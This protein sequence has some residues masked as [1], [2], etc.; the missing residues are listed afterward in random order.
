VIEYILF[1]FASP[2]DLIIS[3]NIYESLHS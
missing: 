2:L 3:L 1:Q